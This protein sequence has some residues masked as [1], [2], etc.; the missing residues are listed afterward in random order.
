MSAG[1]DAQDAGGLLKAP[2]CKPLHD[3]DVEAPR[4]GVGQEPFPAD[5]ARHV[6]R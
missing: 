5:A 2:G 1:R 3:F 4:G 6:R